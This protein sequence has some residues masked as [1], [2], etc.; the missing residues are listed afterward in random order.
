MKDGI[1]VR[2]RE[3]GNTLSLCLRSSA[4]GVGLRRSTA[5]TCHAEVSARKSFM[6]LATRFFSSFP[7]SREGRTMFAAFEACSDGYVWFRWSAEVLRW[8]RR[9]RLDAC[10][11]REWRYWGG[12]DESLSCEG[13]AK[14][15]A[16]LNWIR[17]FVP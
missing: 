14:D 12:F 1:L 15:L 10:L 8:K 11:L 7:I 17:G 4:C 13:C 6:P 3:E 16:I 9:A 2:N 5:R